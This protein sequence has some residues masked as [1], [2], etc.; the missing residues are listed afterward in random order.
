MASKTRFSPRPRFVVEVDGEGTSRLIC[1]VA[2][3]WWLFYLLRGIGK[4]REQI[5]RIECEGHP[6]TARSL[7]GLNCYLRAGAMARWR[8]RRWDAGKELIGW[9]EWARFCRMLGLVFDGKGVDR[10][11]A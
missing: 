2:S 6:L 3:E 10:V 8:S 5:V 7:A 9:G 11:A 4:R 1:G